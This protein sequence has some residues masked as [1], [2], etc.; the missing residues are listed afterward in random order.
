MSSS[1]CSAASMACRVERLA[2]LPA[3]PDDADPGPGEDADGVR[4]PAASGDGATVDVGGPGVSGS[5]AVGEV[6][7]CC[8]ELL[9]AGPPEH[10]LLPLAGLPSRGRRSG[11]G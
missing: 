4:V 5:A 8:S 11:Q 9:V 7:D 1:E 3:A 10:G 6:H 2:V